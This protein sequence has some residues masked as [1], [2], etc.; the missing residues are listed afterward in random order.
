MSGVK[1]TIRNV[2][3]VQ[4]KL[5]NCSE[6]LF[7]AGLAK[8]NI[9]TNV[10]RFE[11]LSSETKTYSSKRKADAASRIANKYYESP[12]ITSVFIESAE[13]DIIHTNP[14]T[15]TNKSTELSPLDLVPESEFSG[16]VTLERLC[17]K[18]PL[19]LRKKFG[20]VFRFAIA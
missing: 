19:M 18:Y 2:W 14:K 10:S 8:S 4:D 17:G 5:P 1:K 20:D 6:Q 12:F 11:P 15:T 16:W 3:V 13:V 9:G 7:F